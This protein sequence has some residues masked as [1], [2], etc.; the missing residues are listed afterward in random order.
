MHHACSQLA[1]GDLA[2]AATPAVMA[3]SSQG[4]DVHGQARS[5]TTAQ[6]TSGYF[7]IS[8]KVSASSRMTWGVSAASNISP[9]KLV[10]GTVPCG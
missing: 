5:M 8:R 3:A 4:M 9:M 10:D 6:K 2:S 7:L 1:E